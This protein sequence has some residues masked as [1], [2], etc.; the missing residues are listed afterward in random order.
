MPASKLLLVDGTSHVFLTDGASFLLLDDGPDPTPP[1]NTGTP[2]GADS[3]VTW[4]IEAALTSA[5]GDGVW[6]AGIWDVATWGADITWTDIT[7]HVK[8]F[9][10]R[11]KFGRDLQAWEAG[12]A[13]VILK[14]Q[15]GR[16]SPSNLTGPYVSAGVTQIRPWRPLRISAIYAGVTYRLFTGYAMAWEEDYGK[17]GSAEANVTVPCVDEMARLAAFNGYAQTPQG[18]GE[19]SGERIQRILN[20]AGHTGG[21]NIDVGRTTVQATTLAAN[22]VTE[23]KLTADSEGG[24]VYID[25]DG[26]VV[27]ENEYALLENTRSNTSQATYGDAVGQI[28]Y[29]DAPLAYNGDL[30]QNIA[31][32]ARAGG[33]AQI[34]ADNVSR[35]LYGDHQAARTDLVCESDAQVAGLAGFYV[36]RYKDPELRFV[37]VTLRARENLPVMMPQVLGRLVR[38]KVT[39]ARETPDGDTISR[40]CHIAGVSHTVTSDNWSTTFDLWSATPYAEFNTSLWD[41]GVFDTAEF[42]Y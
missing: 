4:L 29:E 10:T 6:D 20:N 15:D 17:A 9:T 36:A 2:W 8:E 33:T 12:S 7:A 40:V 16:F 3:S 31:S 37:S 11:R 26:T 18:S 21:R 23:L 42:F 1:A 28:A 38:D 27:F 34:A 19:T 25:T 13:Q 39:V 24:A 14:N 5:S 35:A 30:I 32:F 41:V 22:A